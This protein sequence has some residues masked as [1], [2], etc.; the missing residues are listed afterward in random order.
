MLEIKLAG[1]VA[2]G[3]ALLGLKETE[4][5]A[6]AINDCID[7]V[8]DIGVAIDPEVV[9]PGAAAAGRR[10]AALAKYYRQMLRIHRKAGA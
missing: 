8:I 3:V 4:A 1:M 2:E 7:L 10:K 6:V 5:V 9:P